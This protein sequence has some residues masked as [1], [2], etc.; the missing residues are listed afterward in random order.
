MECHEAMT[1]PGAQI[2]GK[3]TLLEVYNIDILSR[4]HIES[5]SL[6]TQ[7]FVVRTAHMM[8]GYINSYNYPSTKRVN[9]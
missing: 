3:R 1:N 5:I 2:R 6:V 9:V 7:D 8:S 4:E